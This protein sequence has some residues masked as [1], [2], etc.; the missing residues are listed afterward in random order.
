MT[1]STSETTTSLSPTLTVPVPPTTCD[2]LSSP[3]S[4]PASTSAPAPNAEATSPREPTEAGTSRPRARHEPVDH[5]SLLTGSIHVTAW[6]DAVIDQLGHD[7]RSS[8]VEQFWLGILGPSTTWLLRRFVAGLETS[9]QGFSL[10]VADTARS[11]GL[12]A[13]QGRQSPFVRSLGR[14][15]QFRMARWS[16]DELQVRRKLPPLNRSQIAR[17]PESLQASHA[18]WLTLSPDTSDQAQRFARAETLARSLFDLGEER[19]SVEQW[20]GRWRFPAE[21]CRQAADS[22]W[23]SFQECRPDQLV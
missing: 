3:S 12:G 14:T 13:P 16:G 9:P 20:L 4:E 21:L 18:A 10:S 2:A 7:P 15:C 1:S 17:L 22:A 8:Y 23:Q 11:L 19:D 5:P 6:P